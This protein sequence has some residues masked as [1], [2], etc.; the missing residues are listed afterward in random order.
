MMDKYARGSTTRLV[1]S[2][3][4]GPLRSFTDAVTYDDALLVDALLKRGKR[5][6]VARAKIVGNA[7]LYVQKY[8]TA[9]DGRLRAA[10]APKPL[11]APGDVVVRD[12]TSDVG[13]MAWVGQDTGATLRE[14]IQRRVFTRR[15]CDRALVAGEHLRYSRP[16]RIYRRL[17]R[18]RDEDRVEV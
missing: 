16:R 11:R 10:Y 9:E 7:F 1:Q 3:D 18:A 17:H 13:N 2:F 5:G 4:G 6:D 8:D 14:N 15:A 12:N